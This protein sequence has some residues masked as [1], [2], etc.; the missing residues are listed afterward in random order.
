MKRGGMKGRWH[1][2]L[3][4][5][6][7]TLMPGFAEDVEL[8]KVLT[9]LSAKLQWDPL[10]QTGLLL[11]PEHRISFTAES[12]ENSLPFII[13]GRYVIYL[14]PPRYSGGTLFFPSETLQGLEKALASIKSTEQSLYRIA[15]I[16]ID[17]GHGGRDSGA[18]AEHTINKKKVTLQ[19]KNITLSVGKQV[20]DALVARYPEKRILMTRTG[21]TYPT[22]EDRV[23]IANSIQL[24]E[25]E[26]ILYIS[27]HAN[28]SFNKNARG[29]EVWYLS[30]EY[31][32]TVVDPK[33]YQE[34]TE[35]IPILNA[36]LEEE[37]T[38]ESILLAKYILGQLD[39]SLGDRIPS[40]GLKA[41]EWF[42]VRNAK[43]PSV[44]VELGFITNLQDAILM[45]DAAYLQKFSEALYKGIAEFVTNF[46]KTG[47]FTT[48]R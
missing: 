4:L 1:L 12:G 41:E 32:R 31:R 15:A 5:F 23:S 22:L 35:V 42:V 21:D 47:G 45:N 25:H 26:A 16:V 13:D 44:L 46:E 6:F 30:P 3:V 29:Y 9:G 18:V 8:S 7:V 14:S 43:M 20:Y 27:I 11:T 33:K 10:L 40:R 34:S 39:T 38:T 48:S 28:A 17:P 19:E 36:M 2:L 24:G 37:F